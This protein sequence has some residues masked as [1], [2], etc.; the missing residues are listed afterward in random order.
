MESA[1][2][3]THPAW[4]VIYGVGI[5]FFLVL[6]GIFQEGIMTVPYDGALFQY[7]VFLVL[8]NRLAAVVFGLVMAVSKGEQLT[9]QAPLWKYLIV[10]LSNV[11]ASTCQYEALKYVSFAVQ[12]LGKSFKMMPV[13]IWGMII[14]GKSYGLRDWGVALAVTLGCTEFLMTG[15]TNS[16]VDS[17]NSMWG[18]VLLGGFLALD[19]LTSTFQEKLFKEHQTTKYNQMV[20]INSLS[21]TVSTV[22][23]LATGD[24]V[25]AIGFGLAHPKFLLDS[26]LLSGSAVASQ[27]C[28][29]SQVKEFGALVFAATM[30]V[31][32]VVSILVSYVKYHNPV[33]GL[34]ILGL[35]IIFAALS[36]KS[37]SGLLKAQDPEKKPLMDAEKPADAMDKKV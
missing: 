11:Y 34:Q 27:W 28:I 15:P 8:C 23:L 6:Y 13:M 31:R 4:C 16:K 3:Q 24:L 21:A 36:W 12:M 22:T 29:Y 1:Q 2:T 26:A 5:I 9:N 7:S 35:V 20:Y 37:L 14:S 32:Q 18:F 25:P 30:N 33:T 19:G 17:G 10:S